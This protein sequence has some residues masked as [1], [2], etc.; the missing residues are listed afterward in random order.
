MQETHYYSWTN[1]KLR[2]LNQNS[3]FD[4]TLPR[5]KFK[6]TSS[7]LQWLVSYSM[8]QLIPIAELN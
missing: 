6:D 1:S 8:A 3:L 5:I 7:M 4:K 2:K